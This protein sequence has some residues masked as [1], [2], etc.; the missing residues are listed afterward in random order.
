MP[1]SLFTQA[2]AN[3]SEAVFKA[4]AQHNKQKPWKDKKANK[5]WKEQKA[6]QNGR[7]SPAQIFEALQDG[8]RRI[9]PVC[10]FVDGAEL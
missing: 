8:I 9:W 4:I 1:A 3:S 6:K 5:P 2:A 7:S 10:A